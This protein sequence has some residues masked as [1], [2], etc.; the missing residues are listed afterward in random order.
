MKYTPTIRGRCVQLMLL[1]QVLTQWRRLVA[2]MKAMD[3]LHW[4]VHAI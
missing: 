2:F 3:L 1:E 4:A